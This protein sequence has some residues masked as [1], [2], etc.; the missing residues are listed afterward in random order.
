ML[1]RPLSFVSLRIKFAAR[2]IDR[3][4]FF[5]LHILSCIIIS[6]CFSFLFADRLQNDSDEN[7]QTIP[8]IGFNVEVLQYKN[9]K[10]QV[11]DEFIFRL[12]QNELSFMQTFL[13]FF[14]INLFFN[15]VLYL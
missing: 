1:E 2:Y 7:I 14:N 11:C 4:V 9:I 10:F 12:L 6:H 5:L 3:F 15:F 8:T 13:G